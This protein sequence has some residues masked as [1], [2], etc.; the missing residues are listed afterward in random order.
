M[1]LILGIETSCDE[2]SIALVRNGNEVISNIVRTQ[3]IHSQYGGVV[4]DLS[5]REHVK[6]I[7]SV[8]AGAFE[9][10]SLSINDIDAIAVVNGPGLIGSLMAGV[11]FAKG[12]SVAT[13]K[14][15]IAVDHVQAHIYAIILSGHK[16]AFPFIALTVSGGHTSLFMVK[17]GFETEMLGH[18]VDDAAG[19]AFDKCAKML[20]LGYPGGP[21]IDKAARNSDRHFH[22]FPVADGG[23]YNY[24]FSG[25]KTSVLYYLNSK[26]K[27]FINKHMG[28][29]CASIQEAI[30]DQLIKKALRLMK[31]T[32]VST[33]VLA[34]GVSANSRLRKKCLDELNRKGYEC[35]VPEHQYCTDNAANAGGLGYLKYREGSSDLTMNVYSR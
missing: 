8:F 18:T 4:P 2:T 10:I 9:G 26:E 20:G 16:P 6:F 28:D 7:D 34:G 21:A 23:R 14:P 24:S 31:D 32:S 25:L 11:M 29:I 1:T 22:K 3:D 19:E 30:A 33:L 13:G 27:Y 5:S 12:L 17:E 15:L 35:F